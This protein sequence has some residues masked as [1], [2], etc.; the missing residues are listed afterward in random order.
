MICNK[1]GIELPDDATVCTQC[2][3]V[4]ETAP[5]AEEPVI[6]EETPAQTPAA[7]AGI[8]EKIGAF[9]AKIPLLGKI[10]FL[11]TTAGILVSAIAILCVL[12]I[13]F[14]SVVA[15]I[16]INSSPRSI[17]KKYVKAS[18]NGDRK[19]AFSM[20]AGKMKQYFQDRYEDPEAKARLFENME[21]NCLEEGVRAKVNNF[22][23]YYRAYQKLNKAE[24]KEEFGALY[25]VTVKVEKVERMTPE[26][27]EYLRRYYSSE[28]YEEYI[29]PNRIR[30][31]KLVHLTVSIRG[32]EDIDDVETMELTVSMIKYKGKWKVA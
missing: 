10:K 31:G 11:Q 30:K 17:A 23:Q 20:Q 9:V 21:E 25:I 26:K 29:N 22:N 8:F 19:A 2:G 3:E 32:I 5:A 27:L 12:A 28:N 24:M 15:I 16:A 1:C 14:T 6:V 13:L 7:K 18:V 4:F